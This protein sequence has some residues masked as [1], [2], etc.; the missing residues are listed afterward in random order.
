MGQLAYLAIPRDLTLD[1]YLRLL[2]HS[3][4][5]GGIATWSFE[6]DVIEYLKVCCCDVGQ[7]KIIS[8]TVEE[9]IR[10][11]NQMRVGFYTALPPPLLRRS[12][13]R[14]LGI[15]VGTYFLFCIVKGRWLAVDWTATFLVTDFVGFVAIPLVIFIFLK[16][17][18]GFS[19]RWHTFFSGNFWG[20]TG[21]LC[22]SIYAMIFFSIA[23]WIPYA[24]AVSLLPLSLTS[25]AI[26][27][28]QALPESGIKRFVV[29][30]YLVLS[31]AVVEEFIYRVCIRILVVE[32]VERL[33]NPIY[34]AGSALLFGLSHVWHG[35]AVVVAATALGMVAG[36]FI[37]WQRDIRPLMVGHAFVGAL[38]YIFNT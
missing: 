37:C 26:N 3:N 19:L 38:P 18:P 35:M 36:W 11:E 16:R 12:Q 32:S 13:V 9:R 17:T 5:S 23:Y 31:A 33:V 21:V 15:L 24:L 25:D 6:H 14:L 20:Q 22:T 4:N 8:L 10:L 28:G 29:T 2:V 27:Y 7:F 30:S 1:Q 34:L